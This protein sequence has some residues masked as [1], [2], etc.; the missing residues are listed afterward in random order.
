M[1]KQK[2]VKVSEIMGFSPVESKGAY[3]SKLL[4]ESEGVGS[5]K[6]MVAHGTMRPNYGKATLGRGVHPVPYDEAYYILRG[7]ARVEFGDGGEESYEVGPDT[8]VFI[9]ADTIHTII[10]TGTEDLEFLG[11]WPIMPTEGGVNSICDERK[12]AWG[13]SFRKVDSS[14]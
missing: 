6:L 8:A 12:R 2:I 5:S 7:K 10:N 13:T 11:I 9:P 1:K 14:V 3:I 4:I